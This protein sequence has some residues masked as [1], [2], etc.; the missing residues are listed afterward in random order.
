MKKPQQI[1]DLQIPNDDYK[2]A[3]VM[4]RDKL[5][6]E[7]PN[8]WFYVGADSRDLSFAKV[9][10]TMGDLTS[11]SYGTNNPN[12]YLFCA[13]QCQQSTTEAQ[14]KS[15][16]KSA[17]SYLDGVF[18]AENGQTKRARHMESQRL[19]ECYYDVNFEDFLS[20]CMT[21]YWIITSAISRPVV[22]KM[23]QAVME[24][25]HLRG[26]SVLSLNPKL[27]GIS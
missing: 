11:R 23:K 18:C 14:L 24:A 25:M 6:F 17:I 4:E 13:F 9:G 20:R 27:K 10:I 26:S 5:N 2:M 1:Y 8:K 7:S 19:S 3:A 15:I 16:E 21:T 12:F 22:S